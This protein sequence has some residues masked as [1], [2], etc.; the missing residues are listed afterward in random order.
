ME[1]KNL[2]KT[3]NDKLGIEVEF[4]EEEAAFL[5]EF[6]INHLLAI[7]SAEYINGA[8]QEVNDAAVTQI[9]GNETLN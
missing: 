7:G 3:V 6:A 9:T 5:I 1:I 8:Y 4:D 2:Q